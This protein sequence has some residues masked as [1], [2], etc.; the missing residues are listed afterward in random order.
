MHELLKTTRLIN[1]HDA[2]VRL[3]LSVKTLR[4]WRSRGS[5]PSRN[6][7]IDPR[8][9]RPPQER[10][11]AQ[12]AQHRSDGLSPVHLFQRR[13]SQTHGVKAGLKS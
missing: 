5:G 2:A 11:D 4:G 6:N 7:K 8:R 1:E 10:W 12:L 9:P 3:G 13:A